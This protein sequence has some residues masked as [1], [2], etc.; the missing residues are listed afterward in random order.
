VGHITTIGLSGCGLTKDVN[1]RLCEYCCYIIS[2]CNITVI[3]LVHLAIYCATAAVSSSAE[4]RC[5]N[6]I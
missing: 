4:H 6:F 5:V 2:F 3:N 1:K